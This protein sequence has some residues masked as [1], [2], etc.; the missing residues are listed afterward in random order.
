MILLTSQGAVDHE[1]EILARAGRLAA[2]AEN[3]ASYFLL[4]VQDPLEASLWIL[5]SFHSPLA[6]VPYGA[7]LPPAA[8]AEL[9]H[10]LPAGAVVAFSEIAERKAALRSKN[11]TSPW[12]VIFS[13]GSTG[14]PK[15]LALS[16][17]ALR[18][19]AEAHRAHLGEA[20]SWL[21]DLPLQ[22]IGGFSILSRGYFL[23]S[24]VAVGGQA[25]FDPNRTRTWLH[26]GLVRGIS[27][28][29][30]TLARLLAAGLAKEESRHLKAALVGGAPLEHLL[31]KRALLAGLPVLR[32]YGLTENCSQVATETAP[33]SGL[34]PLPGVKIQIAEDGEIFLRSPF[35]AEGV[36]QFGHLQ[37]LPEN[38]GGY[39]T[40]DIGAITDSSL[41]VVGRKSDLIISG[42]LNIFPTEVEAALTGCAGLVDCAVTSVPDETWG[43]AVCA[44]L[45]GEPSA[46]TV[47]KHAALSLDPR[48]IPKHW[49]TLSEIP[50]SAT[51]KVLRREL[52]ELVKRALS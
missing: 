34:K 21:L 1:A 27:L 5:A 31:H 29:P 24:T 38:Q 49:V 26:T 20:P 42:G 41:E 39:A 43:E 25:K 37:S 17:R 15:G 6:V 22:H 30:T 14:Q 7:Q 2:S 36:F 18:A 46:E 52:R 9:R 50:R 11:T 12:A 4:P 19:S 32:T 35:L 28:V 10:Q 33:G 51:G 44:A 47:K 48:K 45:V 40:G 13:S 23:Q 8:L 16:G 3:G